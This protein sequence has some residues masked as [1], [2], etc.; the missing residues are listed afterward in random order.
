MENRHF[1]VCMPG[2]TTQGNWVVIEERAGGS[3]YAEGKIF[4][5][6]KALTNSTN[7]IAWPVNGTP[8]IFA[9][10]LRE[11]TENEIHQYLHYGVTN[12]S[13]IIEHYEIY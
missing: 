8:G 11:A 13:D 3:G 4:E 12:I 5:A 9:Q 1:F 7:D 6:K 10:A 2:F